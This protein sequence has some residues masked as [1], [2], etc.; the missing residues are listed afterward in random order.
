MS[1]GAGGER[2][3]VWRDEEWIVRPLTG[4]GSGGKTYRC[5][6]CDQQIPPG[7][8]HLVA[9]PDHGGVDDRR[10]WHTSCWNARDR[11]G[12]RFPRSRNAFR[13]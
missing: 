12:A 6:G 1:L 2:T 5:P 7:T 10:H 4:A 9:W 11:R 3:E 8:P 13:R